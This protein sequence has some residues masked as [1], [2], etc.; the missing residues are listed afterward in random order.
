MKAIILCFRIFYSSISYPTNNIEVLT[1]A[2]LL[3]MFAKI[4]I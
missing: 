2:G 1:G 3:R 4:Y